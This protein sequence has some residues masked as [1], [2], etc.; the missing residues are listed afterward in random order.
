MRSKIVLLISLLCIVIACVL[1]FVYSEYHTR[2]DVNQVEK[3]VVWDYTHDNSIE[4][5]ATDTKRFLELYNS[6]K[7]GGKATGEGG[8]PEFGI[9]VHYTNG[10]SLYISDFH[11][12]GHDFEVFLYGRNGKGQAYYVDSEELYEFVLELVEI[13]HPMDIG[14]MKKVH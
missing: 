5:D 8:T 13:Y 9:V 7:Y 10:K 4:I 14:L 6:S 3:I 11:C 12:M 2:I 1:L